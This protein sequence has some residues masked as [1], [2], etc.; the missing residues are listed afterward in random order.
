MT[1]VDDEF[2]MVDSTEAYDDSAVPSQ[3]PERRRPLQPSQQQAIPRATSENDSHDDS[4]LI[5]DGSYISTFSPQAEDSG[6]TSYLDNL[7]G[8]QSLRNLKWSSKEVVL[9]AVMGYVRL[10]FRA[11]SQVSYHM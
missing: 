7:P 2:T 8:M 1:R 4:D 11:F 3:E 10:P 9:I 6:N 5:L